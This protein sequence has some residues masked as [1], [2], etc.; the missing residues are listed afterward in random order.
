MGGR[1][2]SLHGIETERKSTSE[3]LRIQNELIPIISE[4]FNTQVKSVKFYHSKDSHGDC[5]LLILN[6]G[7]LGSVARKLEERF[8]TIHNNNGVVS[9]AYDNYQVDIIPQ[10]TRNWECC[11]DFFDYDPT[12]NLMGKVAHS[13]N[14]EIEM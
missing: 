3:H 8:G 2:M 9:F 1:A 11:C 14:C 7:N 4:M 12:G 13:F 10:P 5:D 6:H